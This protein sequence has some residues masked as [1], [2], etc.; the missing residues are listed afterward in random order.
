MPVCLAPRARWNGMV[1]FVGSFVPQVVEIVSTCSMAPPLLSCWRPYG[2]RRRSAAR[3]APGGQGSYRSAS[4]LEARNPDGHLGPLAR[5]AFDQDDTTDGS[6]SLA[7]G[8]QPHLTREGFPGVEAPA[9]VAH[10]QPELASNS[11]HR[12]YH[13]P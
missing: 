11:L 10:T 4:C 12:A 5:R 8:G 6:G 9:V 7:H 2:K 1:A 3:S 13:R